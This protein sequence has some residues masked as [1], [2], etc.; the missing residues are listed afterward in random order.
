M[1][2][3]DVRTSETFPIDKN[4]ESIPNQLL[5]DLHQFISNSYHVADFNEFKLLIVQP[6]KNGELTVLFCEN[7]E[8]AGFSRTY[9][10]LMNLKKK[11]VM[12]NIALI[13]LNPDYKISPTIESAGL[14]KAVHYKLAHPQEEIIYVAIANNPATYEFLYQLCDSIYPK[15]SQ[16]VPEQ[17][18]KIINSLKD[19]NGWKTTTKHPMVINSLLVPL[20]SQTSNFNFQASELNDFY[21]ESNPDYMQG[22]SLLVYM[23]LHLANI[24]YGLSRL[25]FS[26][27]DKYKKGLEQI[28]PTHKLQ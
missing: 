13:Y 12:T 11:H 3:M 5:N 4:L 6:E 22:N 23:P 18:L 15:P 20:R 25:D 21:V 19:Q 17:I 8:I 9:M 28:L 24:N 26:Y 16:R 14:N 7:Q 10:Q 27:A 2:K 1:K